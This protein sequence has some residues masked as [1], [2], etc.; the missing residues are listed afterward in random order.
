MIKTESGR[1]MVEMLGVLAIIGVL[2]IG[3]IAG[4]TQAM[5]KYHIN[6]GVSA[7]TMAAVACVTKSGDVPYNQNILATKPNC[8]AN[9]TVTLQLKDAKYVSD[10]VTALRDGGFGWASELSGGSFTFTLS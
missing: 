8:G 3:G 6:E 1:S 4:Y 10:V 7:A 2:S 5:K 9:D